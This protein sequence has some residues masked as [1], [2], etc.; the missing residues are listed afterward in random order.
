MKRYSLLL[1]LLPYLAASQSFTNGDFTNAGTGWGCSPEASYNETTYG[2]INSSNRVA[3]IDASAGLCQTLTGF[4]IGAEYT[5]D[6]ICSRRTTC[7]PT[8]Q[9]MNLTVSGS[10]LN[11]G[12]SRN[13]G[14]FSLTGESYSFVATSTSHTINFNGTSAGTCGLIIDNLTISLTRGLPIELLRFNAAVINN[15]TNQFVELSWSTA[16]EINNDYFTIERSINAK[17]WE[18]VTKL[19]G[20]GN[21]S[22]IL[23]YIAYDKKPY[24]QTTY[25]RLKQTD[26]D[27]QFS[28]SEIK[29]VKLT[30][31][32]LGQQKIWPNPTKDQIT[33]EGKQLELES[34]QVFNS[35]GQ[36]LT[37]EVNIIEQAEHRSVLTFSSLKSGVYY[38]KTGNTFHRV[39]KQ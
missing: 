1:C 39:Y 30:N 21:S 31:N 32:S 5:I 11:V 34:L 6:F 27:G 12:I 24:S 22:A 13:G 4:T 28:Y 23:N 25:Y 9:S 15:F 2:G 8:L 10:A 17:D 33:I 38:I 18:T 20:A 35:M 36:N 16:S 29:P 7:G 19:N 3:E 37:N 26:Y 14:A